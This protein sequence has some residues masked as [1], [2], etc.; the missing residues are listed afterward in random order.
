MYVLT[1]RLHLCVAA[2]FTI[3]V[4]CKRV[5]L[6]DISSVRCWKKGGGAHVMTRV[7]RIIAGHVD[8]KYYDDAQSARLS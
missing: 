8:E 6:G 2:G 3:T 1:K 4:H 5:L 7:C